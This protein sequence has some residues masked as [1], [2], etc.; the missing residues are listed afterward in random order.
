MKKLPI[1]HIAFF[2]SFFI[3][4]CRTESSP[5]S[6]E[7]GLAIGWDRL[8]NLYLLQ[9]SEDKQLYP[10]IAEMETNLVS[11]LLYEANGGNLWAQ[12]N[13]SNLYFAG[14]GTRSNP[15]L[16]MVWLKESANN[17]N[18]IAQYSYAVRLMKEKSIANIDYD[19]VKN[20]LTSAMKSGYGPAYL[21]LVNYYLFYPVPDHNSVRASEI[22]FEAIQ[23]GVPNS[24][25]YQSFLKSISALDRTNPPIGCFHIL[26]DSVHQHQK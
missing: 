14:I 20:L 1:K 13:L 2:V 3:S 10:T 26:D 16:A 7:L 24:K 9:R 4:S 5:S 12:Y 21:E 19:F 18:P 25:E 23:A 11:H 15:D 17:G 8:Y 22:L 6:A